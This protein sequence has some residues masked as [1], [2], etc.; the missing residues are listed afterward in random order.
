MM[1]LLHASLVF[2]L[3][4][5]PLKKNTYVLDTGIVENNIYAH[6]LHPEK[7]FMDGL[8]IWII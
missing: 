8:E 3:F 5:Y 1:H 6:N 7:A 2:W 4:G